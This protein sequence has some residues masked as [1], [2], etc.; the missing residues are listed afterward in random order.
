MS[1][2]TLV[3]ETQ[4]LKIREY[5]SS[6]LEA[7]HDYAQHAEGVQYQNWG[8]NQLADTEGF[9]KKVMSWPS[10]NP[11]MSYGFCIAS[12]ET[13]QAMGGCG[14][15]LNKEAPTE[16]KI[17]YIMNPKYW[18]RGFTTEAVLELGKY[19]YEV[20]KLEKVLATCDVRNIASCRVLEKSG[21]L[22]VEILTNHYKQKGIMRDS[23]LFKLDNENS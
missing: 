5:L 17:G 14:I 3:F 2:G 19:A 16:A 15:Y 10:Q 12:K 1:A 4:R 7:I 13:N 9:L 23:F 20:L 18:N 6:D 8:P 11:R 22:P 21:F